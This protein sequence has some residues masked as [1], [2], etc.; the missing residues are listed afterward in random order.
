VNAA[1]F[2]LLSL[3]LVPLLTLL[4]ASTARLKLA[5]ATSMMWRW[6]G[7][8]AALALVAAYFVRSGGH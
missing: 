2:I 5:Q 1:G 6:G 4:A 3:A 8:V 7:A